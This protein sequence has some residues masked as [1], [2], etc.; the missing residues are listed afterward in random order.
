M[1]IAIEGEYFN[2]IQVICDNSIA[3]IVIKNKKLKAIPL[4]TGTRQGCPLL[5]FLLHIVFEVPD[6]AIKQ[7]KNKNYPN[8]RRSRSITIC[9]WHDYIYRKH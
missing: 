5:P 3:K 8:W 2:I 6:R 7:E 4:R 1:K 9:R